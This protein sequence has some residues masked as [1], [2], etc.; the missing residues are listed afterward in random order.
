LA[1]CEGGAFLLV[2]HSGAVEGIL[3]ID[4]YFEVEEAVLMLYLDL[5]FLMHT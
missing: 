1:A 2:E 3:K 4:E 5:G